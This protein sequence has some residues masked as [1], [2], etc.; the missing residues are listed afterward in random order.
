MN[1]RNKIGSKIQA[2]ETMASPSAAT[3]THV[4]G[5]GDRDDEKSK[6]LDDAG[7]DG[8]TASKTREG[9]EEGQTNESELSKTLTLIVG[10]TLLGTTTAVYYVDGHGLI[11]EDAKGSKLINAF[12]CT[13][14]T[15][16]TYVQNGKQ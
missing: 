10:L 6:D 9:E 15:L 3:P 16:T 11:D 4:K 12:Y 1:G 5:D 14:M 13:V 2:K 7:K 8:R